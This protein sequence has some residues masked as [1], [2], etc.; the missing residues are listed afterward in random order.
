MREIGL[1]H[2]YIEEI[3][4]C[5]CGS[6]EELRKRERHF[7]KERQPVL[8]TQI[9]TR[10]IKEWRE[11]NKEYLQQVKKDYHI[12]NRDKLNEKSRT[13]HEENKEA[14]KQKHKE[15]REINRETILKKKRQYHQNNKERLNE[16]KKQYYQDNKDYLLEKAKQYQQENREACMNKSKK[17]Y[18]ENKATINEQRKE[19][20]VCEC[21]VLYTYGNRHRHFKSKYH[22]I[23]LNNNIQNVQI[24]ESQQEISNKKSPSQNNA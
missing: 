4:K 23:F 5:P 9:P 7:I 6:I 15:Y 24:P 1:E 19:K 11:D 13:Y 3:E 12:Q 10:T 8:N 16:E 14:L 17:Y 2:F 20:L 18:E 21:G 22:Q